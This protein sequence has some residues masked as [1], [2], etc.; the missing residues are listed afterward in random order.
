MNLEGVLKLLK[1]P[2]KNGKLLFDTLYLLILTSSTLIQSYI[3]NLDG[4]YKPSEH[5]IFSTNI[6]PKLLRE[7]II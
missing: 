7:N 4:G 1:Y 5:I 6:K 2:N 3:P